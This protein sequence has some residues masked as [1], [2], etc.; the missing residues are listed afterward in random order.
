MLLSFTLADPC[1]KTRACLGK[2]GL[3]D[4]PKNQKSELQSISSLRKGVDAKVVRVVIMLK[5]H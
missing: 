5:T 4:S 1:E 2:W 3:K